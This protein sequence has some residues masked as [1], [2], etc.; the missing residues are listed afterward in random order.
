VVTVETESQ[1]ENEAVLRFSIA[2]TGIGIPQEQQQAIFSPFVQAD[3]S[4]TRKYGG[5]GLGLAI[6]ANLV[7]LMGGRMWLE[8]E[9]GKGSTF[10]FTVRF[11]LPKTR[12]VKTHS[13]DR[14]KV[15]LQD[16]PVLVVDDNAT[17]RRILDAVVQQWGMKPVLVEGGLEALALLR[18]NKK[19]GTPFPLVLLDCQM[20]GMDGFS[21][22]EEVKKDPQLAA[23]RI[24]ILTSAGSLGD[25]ARCQEQ[26]IAA[27]LM[28]PVSQSELLETIID[29]MGAA[30]GTTDGR[31]LFSDHS[32]GKDGRRL[33]IL[34]AEDNSVNQMVAVSLLEKR[35]YVVVV[36]ANGKEALDAVREPAS[37]GFDLVFLDLQMPEIGGLEVATIIRQREQSS[38][39]HLPIIALTA[40]AMAGHRERCLEAGMDGYLSKPIRM[41]QLY[42]A[43]D[44]VLDLP[45]S[46]DN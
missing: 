18:E 27:Y 14:K 15:N 12:T 6:S 43:I 4:T 20:P 36:A 25:S 24:I 33:R 3:G 28:K 38:G 19:S 40:H 10:Y 37:S 7:A 11:D 22:A 21:V 5:T 44:D 8:S 45:I 34:L 1:N 42:A 29:V 13:I 35:G 16:L 46:S 31:H 2:D 26:G 41:E 9:L 32:L 30:I 39:T 17:N 23:T